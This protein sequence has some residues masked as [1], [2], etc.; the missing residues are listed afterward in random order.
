MSCRALVSLHNV[1]QV[2]IVVGR[3]NVDLGLLD[4]SGPPLPIIFLNPVT[5][6]LH[7]HL[8]VRVR[9]LHPILRYES[10]LIEIILTIR[11]RQTRIRRVALASCF[12]VFRRH[13][14][15][16]FVGV[17]IWVEWF[18]NRLEVRLRVA[19]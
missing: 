14:K 9:V 11:N 13:M 15:L 3:I 8:P 7:D 6:R 16:V 19:V 12:Y 17:S 10:I 5:I 2:G 18:I 4:K 1:S